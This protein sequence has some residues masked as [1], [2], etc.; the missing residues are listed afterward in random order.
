MPRQ[1]GLRAGSLA[2][3]VAVALA[4]PALS[5][6]HPGRFRQQQARGQIRSQQPHYTYTPS[7]GP[8]PSVPDSLSVAGLHQPLERV[9][10]R[11][12]T[13][14]L[15]PKIS[16]QPDRTELYD[17][18][19]EWF[20]V[21]WSGVED[22]R[23]DD[24]VALIVSD[25]ANT[26]QTAPVKWK[27]CAGDPSHLLNGTGK[28]SFRL[29]SYRWVMAFVL[30]RNGFDRPVE[31]ARS[32]GIWVMQPDQPLQIHLSLGATNKEMRVVWNTRDPIP[33]P[34][35]RWGPSPVTYK[36][37]GGDE[38]PAYPNTAAARTRRYERDDQCGGAAVGVGW[39]DAGFHHVAH[40][41]GLAPATRYYYRVG[42]PAS[43]WGGW[44]E[45]RSFVTPPE[46]GPHSTAHILAVAD[47][48]QAEVDGSLVGSEMVASLN[49]TSRMAKHLGGADPVG[50][51][52]HN[53]DLSYARGYG[54]QW[55]NFFHQIE[56]IASV[57][58][59]MVA[60]GNHERDWPNTADMFGVEDSG[61]ECGVPYEHRFA[62][63]QQG[64]DKQW[65]SF[66]YGPVYFIQYSTEHQF[67]PG[68]EQYKFIVQTLKSVD[69]RRT[70]WL[71][72]GG[73][74]PHYVASTNT[75]WPDGDQP[76]AQQLRDTYEDLMLQYQV[77]LTLHGHHHTYQR[78]CPLYRGE[79]QQSKPDGTAGAPVHMIIGNAGAGMSFN[80]Q[81]PP[82]AWLE[83][84]GLWWG[85]TRIKVTGTKLAVEV[86]AD[87]DGR[88]LDSF[89]LTKPPGWAEQFMA[90]REVA[91]REA[92][93]EA[94]REEAGSWEAAR[95]VRGAEGEGS[96]KER[97][98]SESEVRGKEAEGEGKSE[99]EAAKSVMEGRGQE[100]AREGRRGEA[101]RQGPG[102]GVAESGE[103]REREAGHARG[104]RAPPKLGPAC[105]FL[106]AA[107]DERGLMVTNPMCMPNP[108]F[109]AGLASTVGKTGSTYAKIA[110][111][112]AK[113]AAACQ[114]ISTA[115]PEGK[116][117]CRA[118]RANR[119]V[120]T[121][122]GTA[123]ANEITNYIL[124]STQACPD[125]P[126]TKFYMCVYL[127]KDECAKHP[128]C[129]WSVD[130]WFQGITDPELRQRWYGLMGGEPTNA[131]Y[132]KSVLDVV[133]PD[134]KT[135]DAS[136]FEA[137]VLQ[138]TGNPANKT[139]WDAKR[140]T[141]A[142]AKMT[143]AQEMYKSSCN[144][145]NTIADPD[146]GC[147][148]L[149]ATDLPTMA[150]CSRQGCSVQF[151]DNEQ[152]V[153]RGASS[154][155][156]VFACGTDNSYLYGQLSG[157]DMEKDRPYVLQQILCREQGVQTD[158]E[159]CLGVKV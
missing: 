48:G 73:H 29:I 96:G 149:N 135:W 25:Q 119:C 154:N 11:A 106:P 156:F 133:Y 19:G 127:F 4:I 18:R 151:W 53:G 159:R 109:T 76:V 146:C 125:A 49:T 93:A 157:Y 97:G 31:V 138:T 61:G 126:A 5:A 137:W 78:T 56:P 43:N 24:W 20:T 7:T 46:T 105:M 74:R 30:M 13:Q 8:E 2:L 21:S 101:Q 112:A 14:A 68:T 12:V 63:P 102:A 122:D 110:I 58:P 65:Y 153:N 84:L 100:T 104:Q 131:C 158:E 55:D 72:L 89:E 67:G 35:V 134:R 44:S 77:D 70:P 60:P 129:E 3:L 32:K 120:V 54:S 92:E 113:A 79:C 140:G 40:M 115:T 114:T 23:F 143:Y 124:W 45:E 108:T 62:M 94:E 37:R 75:M 34:Q 95:E 86:V 98:K 52:L 152:Y 128:E 66:E 28:L 107:Y 69:R 136:G 57:L 41:R 88:L 71:V 59:Y 1:L 150:K 118:D 132:P 144:A 116:A 16:I 99:S 139:D 26:T 87:D 117:K 33:S 50:L 147:T 38:G 27:F 42:D 15:D 17:G 145:I 80:L 10:V 81:D 91:S 103:E 64:Y 85:Y 39:I 155:P 83:S 82:P 51:L 22:P 9:A 123:C 148:Y 142:Y 141:C 6:I 121:P 47:M 90:G 111:Q 130:G 36:G